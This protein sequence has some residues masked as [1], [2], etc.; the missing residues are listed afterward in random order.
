L[1]RISEILVSNVRDAQCDNHA[2]WVADGS[3]ASSVSKRKGSPCSED[4]YADSQ[5]AKILGYSTPVLPEV[6]SYDGKLILQAM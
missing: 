1:E 2:C 3:T 5:A 6:F 4:G